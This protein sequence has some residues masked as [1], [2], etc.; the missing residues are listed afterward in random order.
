MRFPWAN[1]ILL[2]LLL[3]QVVTGYAG[4][5]NNRESWRGLLWLHGVGAYALVI[6]LF[7]K[8]GIIFDSLRRRKTWTRQR[9]GFLA[10]AVL[11]LL[12]LLLGLLWTF[13]GR[14]YFLNV[15]YVS[16]H[17]YAALLLTAFVA[18]HSWRM[19]F[20]FRVSGSL[21]RRQFLRSGALALA[22]LA[23]WRIA[24]GSKRW[25]NLPGAARRFT[26]SYE[27]GRSGSRFPVVSW[28]ADNPPPVDPANWMLTI[29][30]AVEKSAD[31]TYEQ[32]QQ[33]ADDQMVA[34]LDCTGGWY[35]TQTWQGVNVARLLDQAG[36]LPQADSITFRSV[37][38]YQRRFTVAE[39]GRYLLALGVAGDTL[40]HGHGFPVRLVAADKRGVEWVKWVTHIRVNT[41]G[42]IWQP[43]LPLQ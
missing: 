41:T 39:A 19:R 25:F 29:D 40:S 20:I 22:G 5:V 17:I 2:F 43:P 42:K 11:L 21:A 15:S 28:I 37:S 34:T 32:L 26:G 6:L 10:T 12:T 31:Y 7:W 8:G 13:Q 9:V 24:D 38:G 23:A 36:I 14:Q 1:I 30:G 27:Y 16:W 35:T 4:M 3:F 33:V 18:W